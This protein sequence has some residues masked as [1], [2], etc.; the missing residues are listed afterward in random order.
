MKRKVGDKVKIKS[1]L[2][3]GKKY[4]SDSF[5]ARMQP[6]IGGKGK[7]AYVVGDTYLLDID[8]K[9]WG[10]T[11]EMLED[12]Y[13]QTPN[14]ASIAKGKSTCNVEKI[15]D[16]K[17]MRE[18]CEATFD[19]KSKQSLLS[20][21][22]SEHSPVRT[23]QFWIQL[24]NIPLFVSTHLLRHHVGS[25]PFAL[26]HRSDRNGGG[27]DLPHIV[28]ELKCM[29]E[30]ADEETD[31]EEI[32]NKLDF[33]AENCGRMTPTNLSLYINAQ[34]LIDMAKSRLCTMASKETR[35][36]FDMI[37]D[38]IRDVDSDLATMLVPKCVY[39]GGLCGEG[40]NCCGLNASSNFNEK[41]DY[42][43]KLF[44]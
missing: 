14:I 15:T 21:Y 3:V 26:T 41:Y 40:R 32:N 35:D 20:M 19:G 9:C 12:D 34:S 24:E 2:V 10:W 5:V 11:D 17:I 39:R 33:I 36:V 43:F 8:D 7:V 18:A 31:Y 22:V 30:C 13:T 16:E 27:Y 29:I 38:C 1:D 37:H 23:Q 44:R 25:Q 4:G 6:F 28:E 42:Y